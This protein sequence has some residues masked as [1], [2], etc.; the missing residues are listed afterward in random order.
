MPRKSNADMIADLE[1][2]LAEAK[3]KEQDK[4]KTRVAYLV[5]SIKA[6]DEKIVKAED[7]YNTTV[8]NAK[9]IKD[10]AIEKLEQKRADLDAELS[11]LATT[12]AT[13]LTFTSV[14]V[15]EV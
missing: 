5:E 12:D 15:E 3:A 4:A 7:R 8:A 1:R 2:K 13:Q 10:A 11:E 14:E 9:E 6:I